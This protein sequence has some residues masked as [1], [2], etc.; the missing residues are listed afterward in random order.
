MSIKTRLVGSILALVLAGV[1][2][3]YL[4]IGAVSKDEALRGA[5]QAQAKPH[6]A[7][8]DPPMPRK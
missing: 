7:T 4:F 6:T 8:T 5:P 3:V 2:T 1:V